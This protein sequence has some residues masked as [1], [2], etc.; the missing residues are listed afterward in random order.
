MRCATPTRLRSAIPPQRSHPHLSDPIGCPTLTP[1]I[2]PHTVVGEVGG[3]RRRE[4]SALGAC[5]RGADTP[6]A[7]TA[8]H[9]PILRCIPPALAAHPHLSTSHIHQPTLAHPHPHPHLSNRW[10]RT[11]RRQGLARTKRLSFSR[12]FVHAN[13]ASEGVNCM[14]C[15][16]FACCARFMTMPQML[17]YKITLS[18]TDCDVSLSSTDCESKRSASNIAS[19]ECFKEQVRFSFYSRASRMYLDHSP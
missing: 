6:G 12:P 13:P 1:A 19:C 8:Y 7:T 2:P 5:R 11:F 4:R 18:S 16:R 3:L 10:L 9:I 15:G 17:D 14:L